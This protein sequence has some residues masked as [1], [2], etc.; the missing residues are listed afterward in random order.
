MRVKLFL[1]LIFIY[2][3]GFCQDLM[4]TKIGESISKNGSEECI[5]RLE[6]YNNTNSP[7]CIP[8]SLSFGL[9]VNLNDTVEVANIYPAI[10]SSVIFSLYY[11]KSD[12][13]GSSAR[14]PGVPVIVNPNTYI[15]TNIRLTKIKGKKMFLELKC[16]YDKKFRLL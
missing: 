4:F 16:T 1:S 3:N 11:T 12:I 6:L 13:E 15:L 14:Y 10:D 5:Y 9:T 8:V 7:I 2:T